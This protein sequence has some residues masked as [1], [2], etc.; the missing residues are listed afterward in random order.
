[1]C[2]FFCKSKLWDRASAIIY[3]GL[4][5]VLEIWRNDDT[6]IEEK[7]LKLDENRK[8][9]DNSFCDGV[10]KITGTDVDRILPPVSRFDGGNRTA[11]KDGTIAKLQEFFDKYFGLV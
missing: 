7:K 4:K 3:I 8:F 11:Q 2:I 1:M 9:V 10:L 5:S 6:L